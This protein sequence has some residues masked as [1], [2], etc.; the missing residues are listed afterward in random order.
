LKTT[1]AQDQYLYLLV[2]ELS[3]KLGNS[4]DAKGYFY[5]SIGVKGGNVRMKQQ[6]QDRIQ[7]MK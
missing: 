6:A 7:E 5:K 3:L 1:A 4:A 2:G